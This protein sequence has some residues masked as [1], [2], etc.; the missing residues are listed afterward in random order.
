[1]SDDKRFLMDVGMKDLPFPIKVASKVNPDGQSTIANISI[2]ARI[3]HEFEAGWI[4]KFIQVVHQHRNRIGSLSLRENIA[5]Y[6]KE[7]KAS[8]VKIDFDYPFFIEKRT[9]VSQEKCLVK[10]NCSYSVKVPSID[11]K[12]RVF[13]KMA[14]PCLSTYP[15]SD[16]QKPGGLFGQTSVVVVETESREDIYP[17]D[18]LDLVDRHALSPIYSFLTKEDQE[19]VITKIHTERKTSVVMLDEIKDELA[20]KRSL[21]FYSVNCSNFGMLHSYSTVIG[22]EKSMWVPFSG[23]EDVGI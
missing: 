6:I 12:P 22:T 4:D 14:V 3:M 18:I 8:T 15:A 5:D 1:M 10:Y 11:E 23:Y 7:L 19:F 20:R 2:N 13:F 17:E 9:P 21:D 16:P